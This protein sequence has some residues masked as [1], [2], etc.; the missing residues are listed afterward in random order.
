MIYKKSPAL[1]GF[2]VVND[3]PLSLFVF[4]EGVG[5]RKKWAFA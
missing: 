2:F 1:R 3:V 4:V 5:E